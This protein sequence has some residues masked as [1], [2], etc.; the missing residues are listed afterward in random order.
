MSVDATI[1]YFD[2][3]LFYVSKS[4]EREL[5]DSKSA[6]EPNERQKEVSNA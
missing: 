1:L 5:S 3:R 6:N 4:R 2:K